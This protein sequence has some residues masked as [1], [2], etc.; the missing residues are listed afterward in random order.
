MRLPERKWIAV[1]VLVMVLL[2]CSLPS[3]ISDVL[4]PTVVPTP[5]PTATPPP[6]VTLA[7]TS[8]PPLGL[9][10]LVRLEQEVIQVYESV[11]RGV[12]NITN[13]SYNKTGK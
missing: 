1:V 4:T 5:V 9:A 11:S 3:S 12:V 2:G 6:T 10:Q 8:T 7:P 13:R